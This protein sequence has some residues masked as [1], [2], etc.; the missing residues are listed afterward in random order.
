MSAAPKKN[1][2]L[3]TLERAMKDLPPLPTVVTK[4]L[5]LTGSDTSRA[6]ELEKYIANDQAIST[7]VLR[8][9]NSPYF[10]LAG[11][12]SSIGQAVIILGFDQ[13]RNLVLSLSTAKAFEATTPEMK[14][15]HL[16]LWRHAV[17]TASGAQIVAKRKRVDHAE[18]DFVFS[19]GL[20]SNIGALFMVS[21]FS[22]VYASVFSKHF[23]NGENLA[24][25]ENRTFQLNHADAGQQLAI[26]WKL[27]E[28]LALLV[29]NHEGPFGGEPIP[30]L[31][32]V[33][34]ADRIAAAICRETPTESMLAT[35]D[36]QTLEWLRMTEE[37]LLEIKA[38]TEVKL[39]EAADMLG[40]FA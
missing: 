39:E 8:V 11:Q 18:H 34:V 7:K 37:D 20:L 4:V 36:P 26:F 24:D 30:S 28:N 21:Q 22:K 29:G 40:V 13:V 1:S 19:G 14:R 32:S 25:L 6:S 2:T 5:Q 31:Y 12:V 16:Y 27:P 33:H 15:I 9:V 23:S 3:V 17:A 35:M 38:E 10:G